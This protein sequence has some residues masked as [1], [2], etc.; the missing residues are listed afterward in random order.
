MKFHQIY[1]FQAMQGGYQRQ[2]FNHSSKNSTRRIT[3]PWFVGSKCHTQDRL[4]GQDTCASADDQ[5]TERRT[6][7]QNH[8]GVPQL[9]HIKV[10][11]EPFKVC[12]VPF[13]CARYHQ[14]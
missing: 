9:C 3:R 2:S 5:I 8:G 7:P 13:Q 10:T 1:Q 14:F 6:Q 12:T 4:E 11:V